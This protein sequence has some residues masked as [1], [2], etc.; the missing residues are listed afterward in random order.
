MT[1]ESQE[2]MLAIVT[3]GDLARVEEVCRRWE[4]RSAV[5]GRVTEPPA[6]PARA[7]CASSTASTVRS[8]ATSRPAPS[9]TTPRCT[10]GPWPGPATTT[11]GPA[12]DPGALAAPADCGPDVLALLSD[13]S[14]V[15]RQYDHQLFL[16]TVDGPGG[17]AAV[18]RLAAPGPPPFRAR[19]WPS[20]RTPTRPGARSTRGPG[21]A[22]TVAEGAL[23]V[24]CA[25]A[26]PWPWS[27]ASI[28]ATPSTPR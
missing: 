22:A 20:P 4:V 5:V 18:L 6:G 21:T 16:N 23:N 2:R 13:P 3:P 27:T 25:G 24:A 14:W 28:S 19:G 8:S 17:D 7:A 1:S 9:A 15:Y 11:P 12:D 10:T 26:G